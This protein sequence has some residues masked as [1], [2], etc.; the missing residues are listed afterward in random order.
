MTKIITTTH[1]QQKIGEISG[2]IE[3][4]SFIVTNRG[5]GRIVM[6]PYFDGCDEYIGEY[7]EDF[8]MAKNRNSLKKKYEKSSASGKSSL[9]I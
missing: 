4:I 9:I 2:S 7:M 5:E 6:L 8:E 1:V 3:E